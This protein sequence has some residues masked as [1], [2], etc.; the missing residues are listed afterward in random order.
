[1]TRL[2]R[3]A[4]FGGLLALTG[5]CMLA[6]YSKYLHIMLMITFTS[7]HHGFRRFQLGLAA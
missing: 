3:I 1:M 2:M 7:Q 4:P 5:I 6:T